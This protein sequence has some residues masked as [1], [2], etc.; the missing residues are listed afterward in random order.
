MDE[1]LYAEELHAMRGGHFRCLAFAGQQV[2][3]QGD[4]HEAWIA[5]RLRQLRQ[6]RD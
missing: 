1:V 2:P 5:G 3:D 4:P 6:C